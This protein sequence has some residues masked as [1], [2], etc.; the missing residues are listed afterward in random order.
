VKRK[1]IICCIASVS[2]LLTAFINIA[3]CANED[4]AEI[5][6]KVAMEWAENNVHIVADNIAGLIASDNP[7]VKAALSM[8]VSAEIKDRISWEYS[9]PRRL[10]DDRYEVTATAYTV[11]EVPVLGTYRISVNYILEIDTANRKVTNASLDPG[12]FS[13]QKL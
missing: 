12:S 4:P 1:R 8:T 13:M 2:I 9:V 10:A 5:A 6:N 11:L 7:L 3:G